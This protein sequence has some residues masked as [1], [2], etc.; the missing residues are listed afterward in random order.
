M[1][2]SYKLL[3]KFVNL[4]GITPEQIVDKLTFAGLEV[5]GVDKL[6][7]ASNLVIGQI[8]KVE[9]HPDSDHLHI[10]QVNEGPKFGVEQIVCGAPNVKEGLKVIVARPGAKLSKEGFTITPSTI[11]GV[12]SNG[13]CCA[14][15]ELGVDKLFLREEQIAGIEE[16]PED[17]V[18]GNEDVLSYLGLDDTIFDINVLANRSD[19]LAIYSL[20]KELSALFDRELTIPEPIRYDEV[21]TSITCNSETEDCKQFSIKVVRDVKTKD[22]PR[23]LKEFLMSQGI[24]SIN[25]IVDI[26][27]YVMILTG[28]PIHMYDLDKL[29]SNNFV[30][31]NNMNTKVTCLDDKEYD[32]VEGDLIVTN[33]DEP[34]CL[35]GIMGLANVAVDENTKNIA[36]ESANFLGSTVRRT[37]TRLGLSSDSSAHFL[38]GINP[39]QD[40]FVLNLTAE[41]LVELAEAKIVEESARYTTINYDKVKIECSVD[42]INKRLGTSFDY[43]M[44]TS[45]LNKLQIETIDVDHNN[46]IALP[47]DHR[48]DLLCDADLSE[49]VI[50]FVGFDA[51][52]SQL[53]LMVTT[54][55]GYTP[56][57]QK[58]LKLRNLLIDRGFNEALTYTLI[59]P[60][61]NEEFVL[62]NYD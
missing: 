30:V 2:A 11:R 55:G 57:Q 58:R 12:S 31:K 4:E 3:S 54:V 15:N 25:N 13:M 40:E 45:I 21:P 62:L 61:E 19:V 24:R 49:E 43:E 17:A 29:H 59:S 5:E 38:K 39:K 16:L 6:A 1:L 34:V 14:L 50:R 9:M 33:N 41:F 23:W 35:A 32:L 42:Y 7:Y 44:I 52:K 46:F 53:P 36:I 48:I 10:L 56:A 28:Q 37:S 26:G 51:I 27:N 47:P 22:S 18:V 60:K 8:E 20:A